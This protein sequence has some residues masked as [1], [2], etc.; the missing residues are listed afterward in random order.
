MPSFRD[1]RGTINSRLQFDEVLHYNG[2]QLAVSNANADNIGDVADSLCQRYMTD[3]EY[4]DNMISEDRCV[5]ITTIIA[6]IC[7]I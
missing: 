7:V 1:P 2:K 3:I 6:V 4:G 5:T